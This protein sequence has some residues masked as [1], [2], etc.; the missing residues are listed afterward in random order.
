MLNKLNIKPLKMLSQNYLTDQGT[1]LKIIKHLDIKENDLFL[2]IGPGQGA[3]TREIYKTCKNFIAVEFDNR[4]IHIL[5]ELFTNVKIL[6]KD[7]L[8]FNFSKYYCTDK[9]VRIFGSIPY[10]ITSPIIFKLIEN[11]NFIYDCN[12]IV[13]DEVAKRMVAKIRTKVYGIYTVLLNY[14]SD[15]KYNFKISN[16]VFFPK[17]KVNS[18]LI[19]IRFKEKNNNATDDELFIKLVKASFANRRKIL[20]NSLSNSI[21]ASINFSEMSNLLIRR[22]EEL[23][24]NDFIRLTLHVQKQIKE[25]KG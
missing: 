18:A 6:N 10:N 19:T 5:Q 7:F 22:A 12:L 2:E 21:F 9:K 14:F 3:F 23:E 8:K 15:I 4:V 1:I 25:R 20:K 24:I 17:P 11:R 16:T 13:Q